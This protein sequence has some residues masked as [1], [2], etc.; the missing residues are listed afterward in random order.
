VGRNIA[1]DGA[2]SCFK[3]VSG[4]NRIP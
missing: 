3:Y 1:Y 2:C 4:P